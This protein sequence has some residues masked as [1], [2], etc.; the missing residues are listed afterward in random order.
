MNMVELSPLIPAKGTNSP[1]IE[2]FSISFF[3]NVKNS[4]IRPWACWDVFDERSRVPYIP[5][6]ST[7]NQAHNEVF[8]A[9]QPAL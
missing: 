3:G 9:S 7:E 4:Q 5:S 2:A 1:K 8:I 6:L